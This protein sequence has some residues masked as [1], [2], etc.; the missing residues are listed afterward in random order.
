MIKKKRLVIEP[1][2]ALEVRGDKLTSKN[3]HTVRFSFWSSQEEHT[4]SPSQEGSFWLWG[5]CF[6]YDQHDG[7]GI[8]VFVW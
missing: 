5:L 8:K 7:L 6:D 1:L 2:L 3:Q 4:P